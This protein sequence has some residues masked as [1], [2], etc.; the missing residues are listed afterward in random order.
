MGAF[1]KPEKGLL[2]DSRKAWKE[3]F[4]EIFFFQKI[5]LRD[6]FLVLFASAK[7]TQKQTEDGGPLDSRRTV[8]SSIQAC[9][10]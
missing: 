5:S 8:Q 1:S 3:A 10:W 4:R 7:S 6:G 9:L 2:F